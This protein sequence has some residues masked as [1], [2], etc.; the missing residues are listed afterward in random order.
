MTKL[1]NACPK[2]RRPRRKEKPAVRKTR[3][4]SRNLQ[5]KRRL[6]EENFGGESYLAFIHSLPCDVCGAD[7]LFT[8]AA[9]LTAR[10]AGGK[11]SDIAPL[12]RRRPYFPLWAIEAGC[13][14]RY[15][16]HDPLIRKHEKRLRKLAVE[17]WQNFSQSH[18]KQA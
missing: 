6:F 2:P 10:G 8:E 16:E 17:R 1:P 12:C 4:K 15:D 7:P 9:H 11:A 3:P 14:Q 13:H 5:R 18:R